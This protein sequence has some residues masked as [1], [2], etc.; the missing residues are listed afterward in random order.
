MSA[1]ATFLMADDAR[2][3]VFLLSR[4]FVSPT[5]EWVFRITKIDKNGV[6]YEVQT[7]PEPVFKIAFIGA[8]Q[9]FQLVPVNRD[10]WRETPSSCRDLQPYITTTDRRS[11]MRLHQGLQNT[12]QIGS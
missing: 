2:S 11:R 6:P 5:C 7:L 10:P 9:L 12:T 3:S 8:W 1:L 4:Q